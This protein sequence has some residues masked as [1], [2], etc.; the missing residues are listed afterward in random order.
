MVR[1]IEDPV[2]NATLPQ[3]ELMDTVPEGVR[4]RTSELVTELTQPFDTRCALGKCP[5][6]SLSQFLEPLQH[7]G[8]T[9]EPAEKQNLSDRHGVYRNNAIAQAVRASRLA[10]FSGLRPLSD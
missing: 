5:R 9:I 2:V 4:G 10:R 1:Q 3:A 7:G 6:I 8:S